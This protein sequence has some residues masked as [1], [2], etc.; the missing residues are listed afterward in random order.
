MC[1][2]QPESKSFISTLYFSSFSV[3]YDF[4][5]MGTN[6]TLIVAIYERVFVDSLVTYHTFMYN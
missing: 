2:G 1:D 5:S 4:K 3:T 6:E